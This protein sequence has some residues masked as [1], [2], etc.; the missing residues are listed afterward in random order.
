MLDTSYS[1]WRSFLIFIFPALGGVLF[2]FDIGATSSVLTQ[3]ENADYAGVTWS[4]SV[5]DSSVVQGVITSMGVIG[6]LVGSLIMFQIADGLGRR[7]SLMTASVLFLVGSILEYL[8]GNSSWDYTTGLSVLLTGRFVYGVGCGFA[9]HGAPAYIG[10]MAPSEI[11]G[12]LVSMKE[13]L[14]VA[15]MV[16]G[17]AVGGM[18]TSTIGGYSYTYAVAIP[19]EF[20]MFFGM[21]YLP[22]SARWLAL[23]GRQ[24]EAYESLQFVSPNMKRA[25]MDAIILSAQTAADVQR[26]PARYSREGEGHATTPLLVDALNFENYGVTGGVSRDRM[27]NA[28]GGGEPSF[29][30]KKENKSLGQSDSA[31][32]STHCCSSFEVFS[33]DSVRPAIIAGVGVVFLQQVTGQ[34]SVLYYCNTLFKEIGFSASAAVAISCFKLIMTLIATFTVD[35]F[36]RKKLLYVGMSSML[37]ALIFLTIFFY[38][39]DVSST[40]NIGGNIEKYGI[41]SALFLYIGGYQIGFGP[42]SWLFISEIFP[43]EVRGKAVSIAVVT[44]FFWNAVMSL[45]FPIEL[46]AIGASATF[47]TYAIILALGIYFVVHKV[48]ETKNLT[49]EEIEQL[50]I[51]ISQKNKTDSEG[52]PLK[53]PLLRDRLQDIDEANPHSA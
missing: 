11:R 18:F 47:M 31:G 3:L 8:S 13:V 44:N 6:A 45:I 39:K 4:S 33:R 48:P 20:V 40:D 24:I 52:N 32:C 26:D 36:G 29:Q 21:W 30:E 25:D 41:I 28:S 50:F 15:G 43:L 17:Y 27:S 49:L 34:P 42:I 38:F 51:A 19:F 14:I 53:Q 35:K 16:M 7:R 46:D 12:F 2:G 1:G 10:E 22:F 5:S 9:M 37:L 23:Q